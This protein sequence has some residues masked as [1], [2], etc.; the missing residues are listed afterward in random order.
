M[1]TRAKLFR[2]GH[3]APVAGRAQSARRRRTF[4]VVVLGAATAVIPVFVSAATVASRAR[5]ATATV[6]EFPVPTTASAPTGITAGA[7]GNLWFTENSANN[8]GRITPAGVVTEYAVPTSSSAPDDITRG[9]D[10][11]VWFTETSGNNIGRI[12][13]SGVITE[14]PLPTAGA[15]PTNITAGPD[16]NLWF[17]ESRCCPGAVGRITPVGTVTEFTEQCVPGAITAGP[18]GNLWFTDCQ[19]VGRITTSGVAAEFAI[20]NLC[21]LAGGMAAASDGTIW[22]DTQD[23][24]TGEGIFT[25]VSTSGKVLAV[26]PLP[27]AFSGPQNMIA[28]PNGQVWFTESTGNVAE[29]STGGVVTE[30]P[31]PTTNGNPL[32]LATGPDGKIWFTEQSANNIGSLVI[33]PTCA[34][35]VAVPSLNTVGP[36]NPETVDVAVANCGS[37]AIAKLAATSVVTAP[38]GCPAA[39][40][41]RGF[42]GSL[43]PG[44]TA[45]AR[46]SFVSPACQGSYAVSTQAVAP[47]SGGSIVLDSSSSDY[48]VAIGAAVAFH[49]TAAVWQSTSGSDGNIWFTERTPDFDV[50]RM[51]TVGKMTH[52]KA[53]LGHPFA[54]TSGPDGNI[55]F[56]DDFGYSIASMSTGGTLRT[57]TSVPTGLVQYMA[58][59]PDG[60]V[61]FTTTSRV[62]RITPSGQITEFG[63]PTASDPNGISPNGLT[64]GPDGNVWFTDGAQIGQITP[65]GRITLFPVPSPSVADQIALGPDG[66][67]WFTGSIPEADGVA[68][69]IA[70]MSTTG[71][72]TAFPTPHQPDGA[73]GIAPG[74][75]GNVWFVQN[76][77]VDVARITPTGS[78]TEYPVPQGLHVFVQYNLTAGP[79]GNVW[80]APEIAAAVVSFG[81][82]AEATPCLPLQTVASAQTVAPGSAETVTTTIAN[83]AHA[84]NLLTLKTKT[85]P[86][87]GCQAQRSSAVS[88]PLAPLVQTVESSAFA[89]PSC[90]GTYTVRETLSAGST[91]LASQTAAY[92][93]S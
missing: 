89:A 86:P 66:N 21:C 92:Q 38:S 82:G 19:S 9:P 34:T 93:V 14:Y 70:R 51:T 55:W 37:S 64:A 45:S 84:P 27:A 79:D 53:P 31:I 33:P 39:P 54:I 85:T 75:D 78:I 40:A 80:N 13:P 50:V 36:A 61:W 12:T 11:N 81:T 52:F 15:Q 56:A 68:D 60:N 77:Y 17:T 24:N 7:D 29:V 87:T 57:L 63:A 6:V 91:V 3:E 28:G 73:L 5:A 71:A 83:C 1:F 41:L 30:F 46:T 58:P 44:Q 20:G 42:K 90:P 32:G 62:G 8:I 65:S 67:L 69:S 16:G 43:A 72:I 59:G 25:R 4:G 23:G 48:V 22:V 18:D 10:G 47:T 2:R 88:V 26:Y 35:A 49:T 74:A 76:Y